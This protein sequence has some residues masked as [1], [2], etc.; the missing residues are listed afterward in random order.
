[1]LRHLPILLWA[2][3]LKERAV[4]VA[5]A[6]PG[7]NDSCFLAALGRLMRRQKGVPRTNGPSS[8]H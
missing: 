3:E 1:M 4:F 5:Q 8:W 6:D 2:R 7:L